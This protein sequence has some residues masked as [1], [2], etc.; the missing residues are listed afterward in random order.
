[1]QDPQSESA[2]LHRFLQLLRA[3]G[4]MPL[5]DVISAVTEFMV[6]MQQLLGA[7][8]LHDVASWLGLQ[9]GR[10]CG[11]ISAVAE[12]MVDVASWGCSP[13]VCVVQ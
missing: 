4:F 3:L 1:M 5:C 11:V 10:V 8:G 7:I 12:F 13:A 2:F 6:R 9:P